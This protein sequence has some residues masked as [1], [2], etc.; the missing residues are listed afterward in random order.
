MS[1]VFQNDHKKIFNKTRWDFFSMYKE[2]LGITL[3]GGQM[4]FLYQCT[5]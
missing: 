2:I 4:V 3:D 1:K 5:A